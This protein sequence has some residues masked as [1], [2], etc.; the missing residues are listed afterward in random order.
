AQA[1]GDKILLEVEE[2]HCMPMTIAL[3]VGLDID[4][5]A[6]VDHRAEQ[7]GGHIQKDNGVGERRR[8]DRAKAAEERACW[9]TRRRPCRQRLMRDR[10]E[11]RNRHKTVKDNKHGR[12]HRCP[13]ASLSAY[14]NSCTEPNGSA[15]HGRK[16]LRVNFVFWPGST[17]TR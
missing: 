7:R 5:E 8:R 17:S 11:Q 1:Y 3:Q 9:R 10:A 16:R 6:Q 4:F 2:T 13:A 14:A 15:D 12:R